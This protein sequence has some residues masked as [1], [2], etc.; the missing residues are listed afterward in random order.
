[1]VINSLG[2]DGDMISQTKLFKMTR[3]DLACSLY[4]QNHNVVSR[5]YNL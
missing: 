3:L 2:V 5:L 4:D 1:M